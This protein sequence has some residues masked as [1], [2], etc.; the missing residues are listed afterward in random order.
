MSA[1]DI[2]N[3]I[4]TLIGVI[5]LGGLIASANLSFNDNIMRN[6]T[7]VGIHF[8]NFMLVI[9]GAIF[10]VGGADPEAHNPEIGG[11][12]LI[13]TA[14]IATLVSFDDVRVSLQRVFPARSNTMG[15]SPSQSTGS[16][17]NEFL[18]QY[19]M[20][21]DGEALRF[22][23]STIGGINQSTSGVLQAASTPAPTQK[24]EL[25]GFDANNL[26]HALA[27]IMAVWVLGTSIMDFVLGG[28]LE[29]IA[30]NVEING[31]ILLANFAPLVVLALL[32]VGWYTRRNFNEILARLGLSTPTLEDIAVGV[33]AAVGLFILQIFMAM[34]WLL[35]VGESTFEEQTEASQAIGESINTIW[36]VLGVATTAAIGEEIAFRGALQPIFG[37]WWTALFFTLIHMQYTLTPAAIIIFVVAV[38]F[39]F[40]R[41][42]FSLYTCIIAHFLYNFI[43]L[44]I[45]LA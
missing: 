41:R 43:P 12:I 36:L 16:I 20:L 44:L 26:V 32:G 9:F 25:L 18:A 14:G 4:F 5:F 10:M 31:A 3:L 27:L 15:K 1:D 39:G 34:I 22:A 30:E 21:A 35:I 37:L 42:H 23:S 38:S 40:M 11:I 33:G 19:T 8:I 28:G 24:N 6:L 45:N 2:L 7:R 17:Y 29:G 13:L